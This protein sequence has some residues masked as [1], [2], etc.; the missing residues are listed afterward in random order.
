MLA[1]GLRYRSVHF[2]REPTEAS[3]QIHEFKRL[4]QDNSN[5]LAAR[6]NCVARLDAQGTQRV[7]NFN[8]IDLSPA[9]DDT[10]VGFLPNRPHPKTV[11]R[12]C[13]A[14]SVTLSA[15]V[16]STPDPGR[17]CPPSKSTPPRGAETLASTGVGDYTWG[18]A[19][20][21][22]RGSWRSSVKFAG[23]R[24]SSAGRS[25]TRTTSARVGSSRTSRRFAP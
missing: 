19:A 4:N 25:A 9:G 12:H 14:Q 16:D 20:E 13:R 22:T 23:K 15:D 7:L 17:A 11:R 5:K 18:F 6:S 24:R 8:E 2:A 10:S 1:L 3:K 21:G